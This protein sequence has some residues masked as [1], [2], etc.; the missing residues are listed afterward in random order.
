M[1][2]TPVFL[3]EKP[4]GQR[5]LAGYNPW[6]PEESD[7]TEWL[8]T[9]QVGLGKGKKGKSGRNAFIWLSLAGWAL[10]MDD[11][12]VVFWGSSLMCSHRPCPWPG[13]KPAGLAL[14]PLFS[15]PRKLEAQL[16]LSL[17]YGYFSHLDDS[18]GRDTRWPY[19]E[20]PEKLPCLCTHSR[21]EDQSPRR[22][23]S[24]LLHQLI[25]QASPS[26]ILGENKRVGSGSRPV[27]FP[28]C[29]L[30]PLKLL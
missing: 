28:K 20:L 9:A 5:S 22:S 8:S 14:L 4:H 26:G 10:Q 16:Q 24:P 29:S 6:G 3:P 7:V 12:E 17:Y 23:G 11:I 30:V 25:A 21:N 18:I 19:P 1:A 13:Q 2:T 15:A 27:C